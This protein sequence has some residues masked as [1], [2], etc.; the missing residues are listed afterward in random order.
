MAGFPPCSVAS[1]GISSLIDYFLQRLMIHSK[2]TI[3]KIE[4]VLRGTKRT[5]YVK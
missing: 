3:E 4:Y 2:K 1:G 5:F